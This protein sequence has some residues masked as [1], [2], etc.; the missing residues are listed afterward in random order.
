METSFDEIY[1]SAPFSI[2][3]RPPHLSHRLS[4]F[5]GHSFDELQRLKPARVDAIL[6]TPATSWSVAARIVTL[7]TFA[8]FRKDFTIIEDLAPALARVYLE[9]GVLPIVAPIRTHPRRH[10]L[11]IDPALARN[12]RNK[13]L[14]LYERGNDG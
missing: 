6:A 1:Q 3:Q 9:T 11:A 2:H 7:H 13:G 4:T 10:T 14:K 12:I 8:R 5:V